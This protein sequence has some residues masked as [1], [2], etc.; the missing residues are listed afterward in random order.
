MSEKT[1]VKSGYQLRYLLYFLLS[2]ALAQPVFSLGTGIGAMDRGIEAISR[3]FYIQ[4][5][6]E[7]EY[8]QV[9]FLKF[10]LFIVIFAVSNQSLKKIK[11]FDNKTAGLTAFAFSTIGVFMMP[12][13]WLMAT[14]GTITAIMSS[15]V[16]M[17]FFWG[18]AFV[19][20]FKFNKNFLQKLV[21]LLL[22]FTLLALL[23]TWAVFVGL[24]V[25]RAA[26]GGLFVVRVYAVLVS[27]SYLALTILIIV[28][29]MQFFI[30]SKDEYEWHLPGKKDEISEPIAPRPGEISE[31]VPEPEQQ[32]DFSSQLDNLE[33]LLNNY[34]ALFPDFRI[35]A[36]QI[37]QTH[38]DFV[39]SIGGYRPPSS[40]V[41]IDQWNR[42]YQLLN[43]LNTLANSIN[44][45]INDIT[46]SPNF[47]SMP[48]TQ[49]TR[50]ANASATWANYVTNTQNFRDDFINRYTK[51][52][53]PAP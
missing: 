42:L 24:P 4:A 14:G 19:A 32:P 17:L 16:F 21:G 46:N 22:L 29:I 52:Q 6:Q 5:L 12:L 48:P 13:P 35:M 18:L 9:G 28:K 1:K 51:G 23:E 53:L 43:Q 49:Q 40:P 44:Q 34:N 41:S 8:I 3:L 15:L 27:W 11:V 45:I 38:H 50:L 36:N 37:L 10:A 31:P 33:N 25:E 20:S 26:T 7:S 47:R 2:L 39:N 30:L